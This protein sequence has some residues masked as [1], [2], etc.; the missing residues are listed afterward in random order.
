MTEPTSMGAFLRAARRRRRV[1][2]ERAAEETRIRSDFLMRME[3][4]EFDFLAPAYV[5]GFL[6][7]YARF[8]GLNPDPLTEEFDRRFGRAPSDT[9]QIVAM[10]SGSA[11]S[12][13]VQHR[14]RSRS[15][16]PKERKSFSNWT[17]AAVLALLVI[18]ALAV[19]GVVQGDPGEGDDGGVAQTESSPDPSPSPEASESPSPSP[20]PTETLAFEDGIELEVV[21]ATGDCWVSVSTDGSPTATFSGTIPT[22]S[23]ETFT[24][25]EEMTVILGF[26]DGVE[27]VVNGTNVGSPGG[28]DPITLTLPDDIDAI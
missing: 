6:R 21:A 17:V 4:D 10:D 12:R 13:T 11:K 24:A 7:S 3:S 26:P 2:I 23:T 15:Y 25:D 16:V 9:A 18:V 22:G 27:L 28:V 5:R 19:I 20:S 1:S 8:L 14:R